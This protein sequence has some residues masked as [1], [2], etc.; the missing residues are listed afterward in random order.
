MDDF[1]NRQENKVSLQN[2]FVIYCF[3]NYTSAKRLYIAGGLEGDPERCSL[4]W[5]GIEREADDRIMYSI[6]QIYLRISASHN[7]TITVVTPDADIFVVLLY[8]L[9]NNWKDMNLYML[10]KGPVKIAAKMQK[11]LHPLHKLRILK[12]IVLLVV[13]QW[14]K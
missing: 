2:H 5:N 9:K 7:P 10:K 3:R 12:V 1:F 8:H 13:I 14:R 4:I 6:Q 11:E